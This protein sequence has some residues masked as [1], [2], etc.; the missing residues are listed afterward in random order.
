M[1]APSQ[2]P[3]HAG[4]VANSKAAQLEQYTVR[5]D[6]GGGYHTTITGARYDNTDDWLRAGARGPSLLEDPIGREKIT[7]CL[8]SLSIHGA[9]AYID[10]LVVVDHERIPERVVHARG[11][12]AHGV[13]RLHVRLAFGLVIPRTSLL[14]HHPHVKLDTHPRIHICQ[15]SYREERRH[16]RLCSFLD[17]TRKPRFCRYCSGCPR[18]RDSLLHAARQLGSCRKVRR[19]LVSRKRR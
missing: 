11:T 9:Q 19:R 6:K 10:F 2:I 17:C 8:S 13:F 3:A 4:S 1:S 12:G 7:H 5:P 14:T 15:R 18:I 16:S